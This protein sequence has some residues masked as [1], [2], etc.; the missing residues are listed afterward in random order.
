MSH[1][2]A[3]DLDYDDGLWKYEGEIH[4]GEWE[5]EFEINAESGDVIGLEKDH[6]YD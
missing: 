3:F 4:L 1:Y 5:Y 2:L 6:I